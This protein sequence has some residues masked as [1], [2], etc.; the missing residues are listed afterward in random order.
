M[1]KDEFRQWCIDLRKL[2]VKLWDEEGLPPIVG[3]SEEQIAEAFQEMYGYPVHTNFPQ[4]DE[5]APEYDAQGKQVPTVIRNTSN[6][7]G[8]VNSWFPTMMKTR[9]NYSKNDDGKSIYDFFAR[10]DLL[11]TFI[12]YASRHFKRD[13]FYAYSNPIKA[14]DPRFVKG[15]EIPLVNTAR[16]FIVEFQTQKKFL[17]SNWDWWAC[18]V[19]ENGE[20]TGYDEKLKG[21]QFLQITYDEIQK[22]DFPAPQTI[23]WECMHFGSLDKERSNVYQI[24]VYEKGQKLFPVGL[25]AWKV[26][27]CQYAV[28]F[29][30][31]TAKYLYE[32]YTRHIKDQNIIIYDPSMGWAGRLIGAMSVQGKNVKYIGTDPN[33]DHN[34]KPGRT[35]YH[36]ISDFYRANV[37]RGG[38]FDD[39]PHAETDFYQL[40]SE[41]IALDPRFQQYKGKLDI[42]FTSPPYFNRE[43]YSEDET[44]SYKKFSQYEDWRENFLRPTLTTAVE[45]LKSDRYLLWNIADVKIGNE[46]IPLEKDSRDILESLGMKYVRTEKMGLAQMPGGNRID[47]ETGLPKAKNFCKVNGIWL[48]QE[49]VYVFYKP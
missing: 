8:Y 1:T 34:T 19:K 2:V 18:P 48:K 36:E 15:Q 39:E 3:Y 32:R 30:P 41:V 10:D 20:Y 24:R 27:F 6:Y 43:A 16:D 40:G 13:S 21:Q 38:I 12:T 17:D 29:P 26:S 4:Y 45:Y 5:Y 33:T 25:K 9:I 46:Y 31:L 22:L 42:V 23:A 14:H 11:D 7:S 44:Q 28:N 49:P 37:R 47:I 35:K